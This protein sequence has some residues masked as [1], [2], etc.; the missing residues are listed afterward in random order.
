MRGLDCLRN[1][2]SGLKKGFDCS[3]LRTILKISM[4]QASFKICT[5]PPKSISYVVKK[6]YALRGRGWG[7]SWFLQEEPPLEEPGATKNNEQE[8]CSQNQGIIKESPTSS[9]D[10]FITPA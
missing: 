4:S 8:N 7:G 10:A 2:E 6:N 9:M 5:I 1:H 3:K